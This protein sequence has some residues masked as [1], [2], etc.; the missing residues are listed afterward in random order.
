MTRMWQWVEVDVTHS[1]G[2]YAV[3][4]IVQL[5]TAFN[6]SRNGI[7]LLKRWLMTSLL[8]HWWPDVCSLQS[9]EHET[10]Y[11]PYVHKPVTD[12]FIKEDNKTAKR[13]LDRET[14]KIGLRLMEDSLWSK[15]LGSWAAPLVVYKYRWL[16]QFRCFRIDFRNVLSALL[17][18]PQ[19]T[20]PI[21]F[22]SILLQLPYF[23]RPTAGKQGER[24][25]WYC[26]TYS[27]RRSEPK[28][29]SWSD[30][31]YLETITMPCRCRLLFRS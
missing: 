10:A 23:I 25:G 16:D 11:Q 31:P 4:S 6:Q 3:Q 21:V 22:W 1:R 26:G 13:F 28:R 7:A 9:G 27:Y 14:G 30:Y 2:S 12:P 18:A 24:S 20:S 8:R 29:W 5:R 15:K 19:V 17:I